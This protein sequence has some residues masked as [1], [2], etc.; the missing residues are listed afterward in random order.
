MEELPYPPMTRLFS[1]WWLS[2]ADLDIAERLGVAQQCLNETVRDACIMQMRTAIGPNV[3]PAA[4][5]LAVFLKY[6]QRQT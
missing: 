6:V 4:K 2:D 3:N 1:G 5:N